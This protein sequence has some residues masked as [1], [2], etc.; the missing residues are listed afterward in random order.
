MSVVADIQC[1]KVEKNKFLVK[2]FAAY[3]GDKV[4]HY[5]FKPP[6]SFQRLTDTY[7]QQANWVIR[8]H[9]AIEWEQGFTP[10]HH[11][12]GILR[13][14]SQRCEKF[15]I[16]GKEKA[17]FIQQYVTIPVLELPETP[18]MKLKEAK[19]FYHSKEVCMCA[20]SNVY[21]LYYEYAMV[22]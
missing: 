21:D 19:C 7:Q 8:N 20:L 1:F 22:E 12:P 11:L 3:D 15:L 9:H 2:E 5:V 14:L 13:K 6:Y 18:P 16:K 4:I 17:K 10:V